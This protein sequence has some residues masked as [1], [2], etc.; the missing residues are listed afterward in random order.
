MDTSCGLVL[1]TMALAGGGLG[2]YWLYTH[3]RSAKALR[4]AKQGYESALAY[5]RAHPTDR[6]A[7]EAVLAWGRRYA[8]FAGKS[9]GEANIANDVRAAT[10]TRS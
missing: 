1:L 4:E 10:A 7:H 6:H 3:S 5:L 9:F 2:I 8:E